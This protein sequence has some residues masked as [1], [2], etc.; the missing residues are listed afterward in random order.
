MF[1]LFGR[2]NFHPVRMHGIILIGV[3]NF[4]ITHF[5]KYNTGVMYL[6]VAY[7]YVMCVSNHFFFCFLIFYFILL[8]FHKLECLRCIGNHMYNRTVDMDNTVFWDSASKVFWNPS[9]HI[10]SSHF[11]VGHRTKHLQVGFGSHRDGGI[12]FLL[13]Q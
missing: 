10:W 9:I 5:E 11:M 1:S 6:P 7:D 2:Q 12:N 13:S 4:Y 3:V 8:L